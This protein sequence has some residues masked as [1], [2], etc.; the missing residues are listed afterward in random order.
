[1]SVNHKYKKSGIWYYGDPGKY[2]DM[3]EELDV[4]VRKDRSLLEEC[5]DYILEL[6]EEIEE[7]YE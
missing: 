3:W 6:M 2:K 5:R 1:M 7:E 4:R